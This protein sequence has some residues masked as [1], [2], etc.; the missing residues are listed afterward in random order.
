MDRLISKKFNVD[1]HDKFVKKIGPNR[2]FL[3][4]KNKK[5]VRISKLIIKK[6]DLILILTDHD[7]INYKMIKREAKI[8]IDT[9]NRSNEETNKIIKM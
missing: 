4:L 8:L 7:Y 5:S 9:R 1:F 3:N 6:Y 2:H